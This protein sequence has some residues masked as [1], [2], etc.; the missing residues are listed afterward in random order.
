MD[1][2]SR[3]RSR[4]A[5]AAFVPSRRCELAARPPAARIPG[6]STRRAARWLRQPVAAPLRRPKTAPSAIRAC[7]APPRRML[8]GTAGDGDNAGFRRSTTRS[9][10][11]TALRDCRRVSGGD[12]QRSAHDDRALR[13]IPKLQW[14]NNL[15]AVAPTARACIRRRGEHS[16]GR[17]SP[18]SG[19]DRAWRRPAVGRF[20]LGSSSS[21]HRRRGR[22]YGTRSERGEVGP[23]SVASN[24][25]ASRKRL[26]EL[27]NRNW[28][29]SEEARGTRARERNLRRAAVARPGERAPKTAGALNDTAQRSRRRR[30]PTQS[31][32]GTPRFRNEPH[33]LLDSRRTTG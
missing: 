12:R 31:L 28:P 13:A 8:R 11:A 18:K 32:S 33:V 5:I 22:S 10:A 6:C 14:E 15:R 29:T 7:P 16:D 25:P 3:V 20:R 26:L 2:R 24:G 27:R 17:R 4:D 21:R 19:V 1:A 9:R 30:S 23:R